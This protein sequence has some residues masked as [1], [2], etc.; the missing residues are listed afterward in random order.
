MKQ[1]SEGTFVLTDRWADYRWLADTLYHAIGA[2][3][4]VGVDVETKTL[5]KNAKQPDMQRDPLVGIGVGLVRGHD[6]EEVLPIYGLLSAGYLEILR[7]H[8]APFR[9]YAHNAMFDATVLRRYGVQLGEHAGDPRIIAYLLGEPD[10]GLKDLLYRWLDYETTE[11][12]ELLDTWDAADMSGVPVEAQADYC[13]LQDACQCV[14]LEKYM[15]SRLNARSLD[16]YEKIELPM[17]N[18][19]VSMS[20]R[21][22]RFD[23]EAAQPKWEKEAKAVAGLD[24]VIA[25]Q[26]KRLGFIQWEM[27]G[28]ELWHPTCKVCRNGSKKKL[29]CEA[30]HGQGK[31]PPVTKSFNAG[32]HEQ[33]RELLYSFLHAPVRRFA[34]GKKQWQVEADADYGIE[35]AE[36]TDSLALLQLKDFHEIIPM[37][38]TRR[39]FDK[40]RGFLQKWLELSAADGRLHTTFTNTKVVSG[41]LSSKEPNL[42]QVQLDMRVLMTADV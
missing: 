35:T 4:E 22:I 26:V 29:S 15:R 36:S 8:L 37:L 13:A 30:C 23:R 6:D 12:A 9:W 7:S 18:I 2:G 31:L 24:A 14:R 25:E 28:G 10:A 20:H 34:G 38:L 16:V 39:K 5:K 3:W 19:L 33:V 17:V 27:K 41:R 42:Q 32:S 1:T 40:R 21:G 11:Y